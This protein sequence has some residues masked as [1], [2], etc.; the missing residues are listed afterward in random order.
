MFPRVHEAVEA[1]GDTWHLGVCPACA[2]EAL[3]WAPGPATASW[4][5][6]S[7]THPNPAK[8]LYPIPSAA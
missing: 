1:V 5:T 7:L 2:Q 3:V 6:Q 8:A 4:P